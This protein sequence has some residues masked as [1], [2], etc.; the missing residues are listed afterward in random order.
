MGKGAQHGAILTCKACHVPP[1][2]TPTPTPTHSTVLGSMVLPEPSQL[3]DFGT[4]GASSTPTRSLEQTLFNPNDNIQRLQ[5]RRACATSASSSKGAERATSSSPEWIRTHLTRLR[6]FSGSGQTLFEISFTFV[7]RDRLG[8]CML[9]RVD[10]SRNP[11]PTST[12]N[13]ADPS[14]DNNKENGPSS[15]LGL[16]ARPKPSLLTEGCI[17]RHIFNNA[18]RTLAR[19]GQFTFVDSADV[20]AAHPDVQMAEVTLDSNDCDEWPS[21]S[22]FML[23]ADNIT[24]DE[25]ANSSLS[26]LSNGEGYHP[27]IRCEDMTSDT[28]ASRA[29]RATIFF[30]HR[31]ILRPMAARDAI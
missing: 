31:A 24:K 22:L 23:I 27:V 12:S 20:T 16:V 15:S 2:P 8:K 1:T 11:M 9:Q 30:V 29:M 21:N 10:V 4:P 25:E 7:R 6:P 13:L 18:M 14:I 26:A 17:S 5:P 3:P 28:H 19:T